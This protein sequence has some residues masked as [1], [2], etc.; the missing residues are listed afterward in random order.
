MMGIDQGKADTLPQNWLVDWCSTHI[1]RVAKTKIKL[2]EM[3]HQRQLRVCS[4][5][6]LLLPP[7]CMV[8]ARQMV[9]QSTVTKSFQAIHFKYKILQLGC[10]SFQFFFTLIDEVN[11]RLHHLPSRLVLLINLFETSMAFCLWVGFSDNNHKKDRSTIFCY[12]RKS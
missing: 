12:G 3:R 2:L 11:W 6:D 9:G 7:L 1:F 10:P 8:L 5:V 4:S